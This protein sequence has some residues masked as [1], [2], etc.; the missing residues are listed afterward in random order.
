M[1]MNDILTRSNEIK[2]LDFLLTPG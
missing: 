1:R 2:Y